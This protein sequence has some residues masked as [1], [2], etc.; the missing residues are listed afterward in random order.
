MSNLN[1]KRQIKRDILNASF[2]AGACHIGSALSCSDILVD[3]FNILKKED[4][5]LFSKASGVAA[6][7]AILADKGHFPKEK[8]AEYLKKYPLVSKEVPG[9]IW[10]GGSCGHGLPVACGLALADRMR[11]VYV[12]LSDG[13]CQE[14]ATYE[15]ALFARQHKLKNLYVLIDNNGLQACGATKD[16]LDLETAFEFLKKTLPNCKIFETIKGAGVDFMEG[17]FT[18]HYRN[19]TPALLARAL[20]QI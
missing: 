7:Y 5:F 10:S 11:K 13:E 3:L 19:L 15:A 16:I 8:T 6:Y 2:E 17:D 4:V 9:V 20:K 18:W 1:K 12:L 14:G